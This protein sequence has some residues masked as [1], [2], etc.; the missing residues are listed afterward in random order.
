[1]FKGKHLCIALNLLKHN[2]FYSHCMY[3]EAI[4][5]IFDQKI[6]R[7]KDINLKDVFI[8]NPDFILN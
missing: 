5:L 6:G 7:S 3:A 1:M 8:I 4:M 2:P